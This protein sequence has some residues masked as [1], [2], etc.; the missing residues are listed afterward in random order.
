MKTITK[1]ILRF[2]VNTDCKYTVNN[3]NLVKK[4]MRV[5]SFLYI[6][7]LSL[8]IS[9]QSKTII[10]EDKIEWYSNFEV[11]NVEGVKEEYFHFEGANY[12]DK[13]EGLPF[14]S[15]QLKIG[16]EKIIQVN[17]V[18]L[19]YEN[20]DLKEIGGVKGKNYIEN[21]INLQFFN[22]TSQKVNYGNVSFIPIIYNQQTGAYQRVVAYKIEVITKGI[23]FLEKGGSNSKSFTSN[24]K[25]ETGV[26]YKIAVLND[27]IYKITYDFLKKIG[28]DID[29]VDPNTFQLYGN[30][31][32]MLPELNS[33]YRPDDIIQNA[34]YVEGASDGS[35]DKND[36]VLFY[37]QSQEVWSYN[38]S[39]SRFEHQKNK[40]SDSTFYFITFSNTG[41]AAKR[42][43]NQSSEP[44]PNNT[45]NSFDDYA[46]YEKDV[47]NLI[48]SGDMWFSDVFDLKTDYDFVFNVPNIDVT[49]PVKLKVAGAAR[50]STNS[51][52][53]VTSGSASL[54][55]P[56]SSVNT[57]SYQSRYAN[58]GSG[59]TTFLA[60]NEL[61]NV[62]VSYNKPNSSAVAWLDEIELNLRRKLRLSGEQ[63]FFRDI[64]S[65]GL[66]NISTFL[67]SNANNISK[68]WEITNPYNVK[69]QSFSLVAGTLSFS[70]K[71][72]SL[73][74]FVAF[75]PNCENYPIKIGLVDNQNLHGITQADM[76]IVTHP[77]FL[78]QANQLANFHAEEGLLVKVVTPEQIYNEFSSG[79]QDIVAIRDF[80]RMLYERNPMASI[81]KY[82]L[83]FGDGSYD[84]KN[85]L[86]GNTNYIPS[87]QTP[88]SIDVIGSLVSDDFYGLLDP[89]EGTWV[90]TELA[91]VA[92]GR[93]CVKSVE[94]ADNVVNKILN[95][96]TVF[97]MDEWRN[98]TVFIGDDEDG[99]VHMSQSN[100]LAGIVETNQKSYNVNK[101]FF[102][103][104]QQESTPG[105]TRYPDVKKAIDE[106]VENGSLIINYTGH[107]GEAG[108]AVE[109]VLTVPQ[110]NGWENRSNFPL[111]V[112]ATCEFAR[113]DDPARTSAGELVLLEKGGGV[114]LLTT[115]RLVFS[116]PNFT[117]NQSVFNVAFNEVNNQMPTLGEIFM[118]VKNLN[119]VDA[120]NRNFTLLGDPALRLA[121]PKHD[122]KT[123]KLNGVTISASDTIKALSKVTIT[124]EVQDKNGSKLTSFNGVIKP[125][126]FD[127]SKPITT[128][129]NDGEAPF[130][131]NL[132]NSKLFKGKV[133][134]VNG[135]FSFTF[136]VP[137]D[138][139]Y[140]YGKGKLSY[141]AENQ[142][143]D[144]NG[145]YE[146]FYIGG[147]ATN[148]P[149]DNEG[150]EIKLYM[151]DDNFVFGGMTDEHPTLLAY[152]NDL[153][154]IN[155]VGNGIGHDIVAIL[156]DATETPFVLNDFYEADL[157]SYQKGT[158]RFPFEDLKEGRHKLTLKVW[159]VYNNSSE[160]NI[161]FVVVKSGD[162]VLDRVY[163]YPNPFTTYTEFWFEHNQPGKTLYAQV[164]IF[165]V[166]G[167]LVKTLQQNV[168]NEGYRSTSITWDG[169]DEYGDKIARGVYVYRLKVRAEN[170][171]VAEKYQKL[172]ILR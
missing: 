117:L 135:D 157:N 158:I 35:F 78:N 73:R 27:G 152:V 79:S 47:F 71:T 54:M 21:D 171:T 115:V 106:S 105:G 140:N 51:S 159:D 143:E 96:N 53:T 128:L 31:A 22:G 12:N 137:K 99:G 29:N 145:Y 83:L 166:S 136:V 84:N 109:R 98:R 61:I 134:V 2:C 25:L 162:I 57:S 93:L 41:E 62:N 68:L 113:W 66:G 151:N 4:I 64:P 126:V 37:G 59:T 16:Q 5:L 82:L 69:Q 120:N 81:P 118:Q 77:N 90:G 40:Y 153:S 100:A 92:I 43:Q 10:I 19:Q 116:A 102:D 169:L 24:S 111:L 133:S 26:W 94:E 147:T 30:G 32:G 108:W 170:Y 9:A 38:S 7:F 164:Q 148:Y 122:V 20:I 160:A 11:N 86:V 33:T 15:K 70:V 121:Y 42:I 34:V 124:G 139:S 67:I 75:T 107:G 56:I 52:F 112:T 167:K 46:F 45:V 138:I 101:I 14:V 165:T 144:A 154:G 44:S 110:I 129:S 55:I 104:Y 18:D 36:Y 63:L 119:A 23:S 146:D 17:I 28:V 132:Q 155:M 91:D 72:D 103:A 172:V 48:R 123:T 127:K 87:Y 85:R 1:K 58:L 50:S 80:I 49:S 76:I 142:S 141:Y 130:S 6:P 88:N 8:S 149:S 161:E 89:S 168:V 65:V 156:D 163:N 39:A 97:S 131:F 60:N 114:A 150:P 74:E 13:K 125:I 95:Y 3:H